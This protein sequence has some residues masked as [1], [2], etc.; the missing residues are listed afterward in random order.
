MR[1][2]LLAALVASAALM[3]SPVT[4]P[5]WAQQQQPL[6]MVMNT[7]L[8][9]LDPV[10]TNSQATRYFGFMVFD[11]LIAMDSAGQYRP[12]MLESWSSSPDHL[13]WTFRLREGLL[14]SDGTKVTAEDC[15][16]SIRRWGARDGLGSQLMAATSGMRPVDERTFVLE[17]SRPFGQVI[18]ALGKPAVMVP[19]MMPA[20]IASGDPSRAITEILGSGPFTFNRNEWV[21]G[22]RVV[23]RRNPLYLPRDEPADGLAGGK[24]VHFDRGE[25][26]YLEYV[27]IDS[28]PLVRRNRNVTLTRQ[29]PMGQIMGGLTINHAQPPF[30]N[31]RIRQALA[32]ALNQ[33]EIL[34]GLGLPEGAGQPCGALFLCGGPLETDAGA[35]WC[36]T[37][38]IPR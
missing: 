33:R 15:I 23:F 17:L 25:V 34:D 10:I 4:S 12:Q 8:Q 38:P 26:D 29:P 35:S 19:F 31:V 18:E 20:R 24:R 2:T 7:E 27:P 14:W 28:L 5:V 9:V 21:S 22:S 3:I 13:T 32:A 1:R 16:A 30:N 37:R 11:T 6:R 36:C